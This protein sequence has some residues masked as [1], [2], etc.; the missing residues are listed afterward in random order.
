[1]Q[2]PNRIDQY[3]EILKVIENEIKESQSAV[4]RKMFYVV[5][6][7]FIIPAILILLLGFLVALK[8]VSPAMRSYSDYVILVFPIGYASYF[9]VS[10][11]SKDLPKFFKRG[12][13][14]LI[15]EQNIRDAQWREEVAIKMK[16]ALKGG[17]PDWKWIRKNL[18][19]DVRRMLHRIRYITVLG[20]VVFFLILEGIEIAF[21]SGPVGFPATPEGLMSSI[22]LI[23]NGFLQF[24]AFG[25]FFALLYQAGIQTVH[26]LERYLDILDFIESN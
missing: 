24:L 22:D 17:D 19:T 15:F 18:R 26:A 2:K 12:G 9:L 23:Y 13:Y 4:N 6:W 3:Q 14:S 25:L 1:M 20:S 16:K 5:F 7:C 21:D 11:A 10:E 8:L